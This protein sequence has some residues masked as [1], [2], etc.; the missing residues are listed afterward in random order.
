MFLPQWKILEDSRYPGLRDG[1]G[2]TSEEK[3][4]MGVKIGAKVNRI[5][6]WAFTPKGTVGVFQRGYYQYYKY[7]TVKKGSMLEFLWC[8]QL[9]CFSTYY[10][11][12]KELK[13]ESLCKYHW[14]GPREDGILNIPDHDLLC[15]APLFE[16]LN[17]YW[18]ISYPNWE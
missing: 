11:S 9:T 10:L 2:C 6:M 14:R 15:L 12:Y 5:L 7:V 18:I 8:W 3:K 13:H 1:I 4:L 17:F 16:E